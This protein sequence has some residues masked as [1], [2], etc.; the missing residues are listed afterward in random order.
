MK[1]FISIACIISILLSCLMTSTLAMDDS[2]LT[3]NTDEL[4]LVQK[5]NSL[6]D[7]KVELKKEYGC[8]SHNI[9]F[10]SIE[11][12]MEST[13]DNVDALIAKQGQKNIQILKE[14]INELNLDE[15]EKDRYIKQLETV[16]EDGYVEGYKIYT[17]ANSSDYTYYGQYSNMK[18]YQRRASDISLNYK[19][20]TE[21][22]VSVLNKWISSL[23]DLVLTIEKLTPISM[24]VT[25]LGIGQRMMNDN[26]SAKSGDYTEYYVRTVS[27]MREIGVVDEFGD[28]RAI[29]VDYQVDMYP[30]SIYHFSDPS[31]Y[32]CSATV[33][34]YVNDWRTIYT[35]HYNDKNY[36]MKA[37][38]EQY[39]QRPSIILY[40]TGAKIDSSMFKWEWK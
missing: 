27:R 24:S 34:E 1:R 20:E 7:I 5:Y 8:I 26:Y 21:R 19:K 17:S 39:T 12:I 15:Q 40:M 18:F 31:I 29:L 32:N 22:N 23:T 6:D 38:Y 36:I 35:D 4:I 9:Q 37:A 30:Y 13:T 11:Q 14:Y 33:S 10:L 28:F 2:K 25:A 16:A 3:N